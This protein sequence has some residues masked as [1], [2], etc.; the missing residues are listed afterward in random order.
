MNIAVL[1]SGRGSNLQAMIDSIENGYLK[2]RICAVVSDIGDA[3]ALERARKHGIEAVFIDPEKYSSKDMY[4]KQVLTVL[5][6]QNAELII[7]AGYMKILGKT[8]LQSY[9]DRI[10]NIHPALLPAFAGLHA[11]K[12]A[13]DHGVKVAGC[14]VHFVDEKL[15]GGAII[16]QRCVEVKEDDTD[17]TLA[18]R[19]LEQEH[20][21]YPEAVKL[22]VE[23]RLRIEGRKVKILRS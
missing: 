3:Y 6:K 12:Q 9:K 11:Q 15:D 19:I 23:N 16:M 10:L 21:I 14:T 13:F 8:L 18:D 22:F 5:K 2:A 20:K 17:E 1:V 4:E 7:L